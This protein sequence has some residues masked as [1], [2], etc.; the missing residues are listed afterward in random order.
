MVL[1]LVAATIQWLL[2]QH[3]IWGELP[4]ELTT[5]RID[6]NFQNT[7]ESLIRATMSGLDMARVT[8]EVKACGIKPTA[9]GTPR[10]NV[11]DEVEVLSDR[12]NGTGHHLRTWMLTCSDAAA[13]MTSVRYPRFRR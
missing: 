4:R 8:R 13:H 6:D 7:V 10:R 1:G 12:I 5:M 11:F 3:S 9:Q 2:R